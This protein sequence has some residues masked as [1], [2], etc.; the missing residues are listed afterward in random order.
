MIKRLKDPLVRPRETRRVQPI[1]SRGIRRRLWQEGER[2]VEVG[3]VRYGAGGEGRGGE[4]GG[5]GGK[6]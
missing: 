3:V 1:L 2:A 5:T 6:D 4:E